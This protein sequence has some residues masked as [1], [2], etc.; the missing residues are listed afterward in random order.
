[1]L[2]GIVATYWIYDITPLKIISNTEK[3]HEFLPWN[4]QIYIKHVEY[5]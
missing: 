4:L 3:E 1:M 5:S 2:T